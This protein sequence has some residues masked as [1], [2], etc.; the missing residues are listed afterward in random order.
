[1]VE[2]LFFPHIHYVIDVKI[3]VFWQYF[4]LKLTSSMLIDVMLR[5]AR[6]L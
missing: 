5:S 1:M 3:K 4:K 6:A 2:K